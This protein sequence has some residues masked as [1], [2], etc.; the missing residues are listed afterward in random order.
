VHLLQASLA[1]E[2]R[3]FAVKVRLTM[4][5]HARVS[6]ATQAGWASNEDTQEGR[7]SSANPGLCR[8]VQT[9]GTVLES[10]SGPKPSTEHL[11]VARPS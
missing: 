1:N 2:Q 4:K 7:G 5:V 8:H 11:T 3:E 6:T 10:D 9:G